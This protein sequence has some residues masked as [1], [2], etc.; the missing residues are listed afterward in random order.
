MRCWGPLPQLSSLCELPQ[1]AG[2]A[3]QV[4]SR[5]SGVVNGDLDSIVQARV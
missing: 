2:Q 1:Q 5:R 4:G 3:E